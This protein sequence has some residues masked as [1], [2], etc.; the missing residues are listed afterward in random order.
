MDNK[1]E[2]RMDNLYEDD[3]ETDCAPIEHVHPIPHEHISKEKIKDVRFNSVD[4]GYD[5]HDSVKSLR[6]ID[7]V[8]DDLEK[9]KLGTISEKCSELYDPVD[10]QFVE[11][12]QSNTDSEIA[13]VES[14]EKEEIVLQIFKPD[15][16]GDSQLHMAIIQ[17]LS[18]ITFYFIN[19]VPSHHWLNLPNNLLQ[20]PLHLAT[21]TRQAQVVRKL[22][23][24]GADIVPRDYK[25][26]TPLHIAC[27]EGYDDIAQILLTPV[28]YNETSEVMYRL[29][30]QRIPQD[31]QLLNY[32]GQS[33][34]HLAAERCHLPIIQ[35]LL[36]NGADINI[37]DGKCGKTILHYAAETGNIVLLE[38][39][40]SQ[41]GLTLNVT[42]YG[43][44]TAVQLA[45]GRNYSNVVSILTR[46]GAIY[47]RYIEENDS[48]DEMYE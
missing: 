4:S 17:M 36:N 16:D 42:T 46:H 13:N 26:D 34:L 48:D 5:S 20:V 2:N 25:G 18:S 28:Q 23:A 30:Q 22:M 8:S 47:S 10:T 14:R 12:N 43:G 40:L 41:P 15:K 37:R 39:L 3:V 11:N 1:K 33:C 29:E 9:L 45:D 19:L 24:A 38:F 31:T 32:N 35:L 7:S 6:G 44:L 27:R 21:I